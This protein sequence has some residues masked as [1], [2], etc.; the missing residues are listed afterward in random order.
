MKCKVWKHCQPLCR[1]CPGPT[2]LRAPKQNGTWHLSGAGGGCYLD[3]SFGTASLCN[4]HFL[5]PAQVYCKLPGQCSAVCLLVSKILAIAFIVRT[6]PA[7]MHGSLV[8]SC[9]IDMTNCFLKYRPPATSRRFCVRLWLTKRMSSAIVPSF[10]PECYGNVL[11]Y[12]A[13]ASLGPTPNV[14]SYL[15]IINWRL[16]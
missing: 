7:S 12:S 3:S 1:P 4:S 15:I 11:Y 16:F 9:E 5:S 8:P 13:T 10:W 2:R 14:L 6:A